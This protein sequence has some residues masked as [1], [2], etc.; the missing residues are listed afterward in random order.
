M[1]C[2]V[3]TGLLAVLAV[4]MYCWKKLYSLSLLKLSKN[5]TRTCPLDHLEFIVHKEE[6]CNYLSHWQ[7]TIPQVQHLEL[8]AYTYLPTITCYSEYLRDSLGYLICRRNYQWTDFITTHCFTK[9]VREWHFGN[10]HFCEQYYLM[11][12]LKDHI[13]FPLTSSLAKNMFKICS[14]LDV[15]WILTELEDQK[16]DF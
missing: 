2:K 10:K 11:L 3:A 14:L 9:P 8:L 5:C 13:M 15:R 1:L 16:T 12:L 6:G 7:H 4:V